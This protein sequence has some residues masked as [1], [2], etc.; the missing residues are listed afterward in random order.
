MTTATDGKPRCF[1]NGPGQQ[2]YAEYHDTE[3]GV[4]QHDDRHL[5]EMLVLEGAQAGLSW[6]TVLNKREGYRRAFHGFDPVR[7]A[8]MGDSELE[9]LRDDASIIRN[10]LKIL[11]ARRNARVFLEIQKAFGSFDAYLWKFVDGRPVIN[12]WD[13]LEQVPVTTAQSDALSRDLKRRGM[14][15]VGST[16]MYAYMQAVGMV[17]DHL[18]RCWRYGR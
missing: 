10:R 2:R 6:E 5:F 17:N 14:N 7:V 4:P 16:I 8:A 9:V 1:G 15:F 12:H 13:T 11:S 18:T 3:W